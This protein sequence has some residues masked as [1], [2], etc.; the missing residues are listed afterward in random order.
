MKTFLL[1]HDSDHL[2]D[3]THDVSLIPFDNSDSIK[4]ELLSDKKVEIKQNPL[5]FMANF[6][7]LNLSWDYPIIDWN[8]EI[9]SNRM[10]DVLKSVGVFNYEVFETEMIDDTFFEDKFDSSGHLL[11][12]VPSLNNYR[13]IQLLDFLKI[14]DFEKSIYKPLRSNPEFPGIVKKLVLKE[15]KNGFPPIFRVLEKPASVFVSS[16]AKEALEAAHIKGCVFEP[17][18]TS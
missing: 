14:F 11:S 15:P 16:I 7:I 2:I 6:N 3:M 17:V 18:E 4:Y 9:M 8:V 13:L 5:Y 1:K 12:N 10:I